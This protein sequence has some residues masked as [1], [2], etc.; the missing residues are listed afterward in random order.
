MSD[1]SATTRLEAINHMLGT[2]GESPITTLSG[3]LTVDV[4]N[5]TQVLSQTLK[6]VLSEGWYFN[7]EHNYPLTRDGNDEILIPGDII[8]VDVNPASGS[9]LN[10][11][12]RGTKLYDLTN[13]TTEFDDDIEAT[14]KRLIDFE[15]LPLSA[16]TYIMH[17]AARVFQGQ[18]LGD[19][20]IAR[21]ANQN[22]IN[23]LIAM[24]QDEAEQGDY[25]IFNNYAA[26]RVLAR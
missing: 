1:T 13:H 18:Q 15:S 22:E 19:T 7:T 5:A 2:I 17:R 12:I 16:R 11:I 14:V 9:N 23:A 21:E 3:D 25:N 8:H 24:K 10:V 4:L 20:N 26:A 6:D